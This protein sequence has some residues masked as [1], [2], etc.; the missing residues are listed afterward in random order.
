MRVSEGGNQPGK[1]AAAN[2]RGSAD[3]QATSSRVH[4]TGGLRL[5]FIDRGNDRLSSLVK[6][7]PFLAQR[8]L[9][10]ATVNEPHA[11]PRFQAGK[12]T[13]DRW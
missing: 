7:V 4:C 3:P 1:A 9:A 13:A 11:Q 6:H 5:G 12:P 2:L 10:R 8:E